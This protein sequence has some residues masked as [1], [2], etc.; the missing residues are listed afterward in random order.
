MDTTIEGGN[1]LLKENR[2]ISGA[3]DGRENSC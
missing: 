1:P 3:F 2:A